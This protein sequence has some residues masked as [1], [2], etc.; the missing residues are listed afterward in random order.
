MLSVS[1]LRDVAI[2]LGFGIVVSPLSVCIRFKSSP[3]RLVGVNNH[4]QFML[5]V[6]TLVAGIILF[7]YLVYSCDY[8]PNLILKMALNGISRLFHHY[9]RP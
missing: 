1:N 8:L 5:F 9:V 2:V 6:L 4:R 3:L 7:G